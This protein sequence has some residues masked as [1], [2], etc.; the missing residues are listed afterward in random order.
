V[1][2]LGPGLAMRTGGNSTNDMMH[3]VTRRIRK[4]LERRIMAFFVLMTGPGMFN[5]VNEYGCNLC[6]FHA[7]LP[8]MQSKL[9]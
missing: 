8:D 6:K 3:K 7:I 4:L 1:V 5:V 2:W 9:N